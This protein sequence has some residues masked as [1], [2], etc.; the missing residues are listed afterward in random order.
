MSINTVNKAVPGTIFNMYRKETNLSTTD[1]LTSVPASAKEKVDV[2]EKTTSVTAKPPLSPLSLIYN[3]SSKKAVVE[4]IKKPIKAVVEKIETFAIEYNAG[5]ASLSE[6]PAL[7]DEAYASLKEYHVKKGLINENDPV[8][9]ARIL[10][11]VRHDILYNIQSKS[12]VSNYNEGA[13]Q[14]EQYGG[15]CDRDWTYYNSDYYYLV[16]D[17]KTVLFKATDNLASAKNVTLSPYVAP[18]GMSNFNE[19]WDS[20]FGRNSYNAKIHNTNMAP[21]KDFTMFYKNRK[22]SNQDFANGTTYYLTASDPLAGE[23]EVGVVTWRITAP[24]GQKLLKEGS[25]LNLSSLINGPFRDGYSLNLNSCLET[26]TKNS[27]EKRQYALLQSNFNTFEEGIFAIRIGDI[28]KKVDVP[29]VIMGP[30]EAVSENFWGDQLINTDDLQ[31]EEHEAVQSFLRNF[32]MF[33]PDYGYS[34]RHL[35]WGG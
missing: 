24:A 32:E 25:S 20:Q 2:F 23:N 27:L 15:S 6:L 28:E 5:K 18:L 34:K 19:L 14:A 9:D 10:E 3:I 11:S 31:V 13:A 21:P 8:E 35:Y 12:I 16:E 30:K 22:Y 4:E 33:Q 1:S 29:Y 17:A 26:Y 7:V